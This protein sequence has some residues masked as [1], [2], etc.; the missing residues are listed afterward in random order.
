MAYNYTIALLHRPT[1]ED[2]C[3]GY[4]DH[5]MQAFVQIALTFRAFQKDGQTAQ[6]W[7][8]VSSNLFG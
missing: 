2:V 6:S 5:S 3:N 7:P 8:G 4:G 1:K